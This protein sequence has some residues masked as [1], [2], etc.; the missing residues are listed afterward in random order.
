MKQIHSSMV[1]TQF[2]IEYHVGMRQLLCQFLSKRN[3]SSFFHWINH[4]NEPFSFCELHSFKLRTYRH[5]L[6]IIQLESIFTTSV[7]KFM[8]KFFNKKILIF[9]YPWSCILPQ[10]SRFLIPHFA[11]KCDKSKC[12]AVKHNPT[13]FLI[14]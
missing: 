12:F 10:I 7:E 2:K 4:S 3:K 14:L 13:I 5:L 11:T 8:S 1:Y 9:S 6:S